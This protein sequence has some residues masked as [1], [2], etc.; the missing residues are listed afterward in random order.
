[1]GGNVAALDLSDTGTGIV[2]RGNIFAGPDDYVTPVT[3]FAIDLDA[4]TELA[5]LENNL[6]INQATGILAASTCDGVVA[7][8]A[9]D[10][11]TL[12]TTDLPGVASNNVQIAS[13]CSTA[14]MSAGSCISLPGHCPSHVTCLPGLIA[15]WD[16]ASYGTGALF[17]TTAWSLQA[18]D[19][20][21]VTQQGAL[22]SGADAGP[23]VTTDA[24]GA[25]RGLHPSLGAA[26]FNGSCQ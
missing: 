12:Q 14:D 17:G 9:H 21:R 22:L 13:I 15:A 4:C 1:M 18:G 20:C 6:F 26:Q 7:V 19:P 16:V 3:D 5:L 11:S 24:F 8:Y 10:V 25:L 2:V 23:V